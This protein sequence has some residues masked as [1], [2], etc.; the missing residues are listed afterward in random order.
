MCAVV[1]RHRAVTTAKQT[2]IVLPGDFVE[3][4]AHIGER[5]LHVRELE[6]DELVTGN[7]LSTLDTLVG[8]ARGVFEGAVSLAVV[9]QSNKETLEIEVGNSAAESISFGSEEVFFTKFNVIEVDI[10][11]GVHAQSQLVQGF[12]G[13]TRQGHIDKPLGVGVHIVAISS[14]N[15]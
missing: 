6:L 10:A 1:L 7:C 12:L 4:V 8:V 14:H 3:H 5:N 13:N 2:V 15:N 9:G 11:A